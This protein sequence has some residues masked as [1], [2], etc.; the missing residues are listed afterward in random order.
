MA[1]LTQCSEF[2]VVASS[3]PGGLQ[4]DDILR[5]NFASDAIHWGTS[6]PSI[7][8]SV[9]QSVSRQ[10]VRQSDNQKSSNQSIQY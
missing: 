8:H 1:S 3:R 9:S 5:Q 7:N 4:Q 10:S 2:V 6:M